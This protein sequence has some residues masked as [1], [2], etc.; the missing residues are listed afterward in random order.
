MYHITGREE[1]RGRGQKGQRKGTRLASSKFK[2]RTEES[3]SSRVSR[4]LENSDE[5][6]ESVDLL[7]GRADSDQARQD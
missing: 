3:D 6:S 4:G 2:E 1:G 7:R 5:G